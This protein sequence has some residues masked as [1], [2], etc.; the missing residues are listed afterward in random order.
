[1]VAKKAARTAR[2]EEDP[3]D[4]EARGNLGPYDAGQHIFFPAHGLGEIVARETQKIAGRDID[5]L[6]IDFRAN[7]MTLRLPTAKAAALGVRVLPSSTEMV[8]GAPP[9]VPAPRSQTTLFD[10]LLHSGFSEDELHEL[11]IPK[12]TLA[13]RRAA[14]ELLTVEETDK[15]MRLMRIVETATRVFGDHDKAA[16]WLRKAKRQLFGQTPLAFLRSEAGAR[17]VEEMLVR[18]DHGLAA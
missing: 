5:L 15:A 12:R 16:R 9:L 1:M 2:S 17:V 7:Q 11:V 6:V 8:R 13:R 10:E 18:I 4:T 3:N 14:R